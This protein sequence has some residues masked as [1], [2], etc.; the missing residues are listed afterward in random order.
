MTYETDKKERLISLLSIDPKKAFTVEE[1]CCELLAD[2]RG[3]STV[4]RIVKELSAEG[5]LRKITNQES[6]RVSYQL[7]SDDGCKR[8]LH[9]KCTVCGALIHLDHK[10]S[11]SL[12]ES[13]RS[14]GGFMLDL[15]S[16]LFGKCKSCYSEN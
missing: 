10:T 2:G 15:G 7:L 3:K 9:L 13:L 4:Y 1:I 12:E 11:Q 5:R 8:H 16:M 6:R 14:S